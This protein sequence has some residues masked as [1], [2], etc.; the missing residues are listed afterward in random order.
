MPSEICPD[1]KHEQHEPN[2]CT[3]DN[4]GEGDI[5]HSNALSTDHSHVETYLLPSREREVTHIHV[6]R[7]GYRQ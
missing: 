1:C 4:C 7:T 3:K 5:C 2:K 6:R